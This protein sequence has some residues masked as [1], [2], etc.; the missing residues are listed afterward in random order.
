MLE[1]LTAAC[2][3]MELEHPH[4]YTKINSKWHQD[5]NITYGTI[6]FL[7]E[8]LGKPFSDINYTKVFLGQSSKAIEIINK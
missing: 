8:D 2:R 6:K 7:E 3:S 4:P 1:K 5:L